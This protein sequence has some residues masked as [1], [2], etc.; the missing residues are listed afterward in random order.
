VLYSIALLATI[1]LQAILHETHPLL[2][3]VFA[4]ALIAETAFAV[5]LV[6]IIQTKEL[7]FDQ[8]FHQANAVIESDTKDL[9]RQIQ[10]IIRTLSDAATDSNASLWR[11]NITKRLEMC[12]TQLS[13]THAQ[14]G[15]T[16]TGGNPSGAFDTAQVVG[17]VKSIQDAALEYGIA[18]TPDAAQ[19]G[20]KKL[21]S[22][23]G[24][25]NSVLNV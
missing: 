19:A 2:D 22:L 20:Q 9:A 10:Q 18:A 25:L 5:V 13:H 6:A 1:G 8:P 16:E 23:A 7:V 24:Q 4:G 3:N 11:T 21:D 17:I 14:R 15:T 12:Q